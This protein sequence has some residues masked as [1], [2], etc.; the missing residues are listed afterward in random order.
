MTITLSN[1]KGTNEQGGK[2]TKCIYNI[3]HREK[4]S[5]VHKLEEIALP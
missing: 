2:A 4:E 5:F 3:L 1:R